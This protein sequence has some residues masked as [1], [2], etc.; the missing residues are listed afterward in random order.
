MPLY[1][2]TAVDDLG[3]TLQGQLDAS[4]EEALESLLRKRG[5]WLTQAEE[6]RKNIAAV[7]RRRG[8]HAV[9][10]RVL[11]EFFLQIGMQLRSGITL[12]DALGFG[13]D[14]AENKAFMAVQQDVLERIRSGSSFSDALGA[15]PRTFAPLVVNLIRAGE[16]SGRLPETCAE[17]RRYYEWVDRLM[18]DM[19]QALLYPT[20][21]LIAATGFFFLVFTF[22][23][24]RFA[25]VLYEM[26]VKLPWLTTTMLGISDFMKDHAWYVGGGLVLVI[27]VFK[28]GPGLFP[29]FA[30][31]LDAFKLVIPIF[32][33]IHHL[34][35]LSRVAQNLATLYRSGIPLLPALQLCRALVGNRV[36]EEALGRVES[37]VNAGR[38]MNESMRENPLFSQLMVQM[39]AVGESTGTLGDSLQHVADYYNEIVPRQVKKLL[40]L[41]EPVMIVG[42]IVMVGIV[43]LSVFLPIV[44]IFDAK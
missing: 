33:S 39:V 26:K 24:P 3:K 27:L 20:L 13:L 9:S 43:A 42:L 29:A 23:I 8:N 32:G 35:C 2:Y 37:S 4:S 41:L 16:S 30:R 6:R 44:S 25:K 19:R 34:M 7:S 40:S 5:H 22:L 18:S 15:H 36:I 38:P 10:R 17:I 1:Q 14:D 11:I 31:A 12:V 28:Y 21:V